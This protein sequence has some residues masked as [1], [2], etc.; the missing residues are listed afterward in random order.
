MAK[1]DVVKRAK[2]FDLSHQQ[3]L[4]IMAYVA[5]GCESASKAY[6]EH[7]EVTSPKVA[8]SASS[9]MLSK[10][11]VQKALEDELNRHLRKSNTNA[12]YLIGELMKVFDDPEA[13]WADKRGCVETIGKYLQMWSSKVDQ[14]AGITI[15]MDMTGAGR[16]P[17]T[18]VEAVPLAVEHDASPA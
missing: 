13:T 5:N 18:I 17:V 8:A 16:L 3:M 11:N 12:D 9:R 4:F 6:I 1:V 7:Y 10:V 14:G 15:T 2:K